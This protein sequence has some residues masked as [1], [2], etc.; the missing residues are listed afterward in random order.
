MMEMSNDR[1]IVTLRAAWLP[2]VAAALYVLVCCTLACKYAMRVTPLWG[3]ALAGYALA[4]AAAATLLP[5]LLRRWVGRDAALWVAL[6]ML[7]AMLL[8]VQ[9]CVDPLRVQVDRWSALAY[10]LRDLLQGRFPYL[11][12]THLDGYASPFPV[13]MVLHLPFYLL[14]DVGLSLVVSVV[15]FVCGVRMVVGTRAA[16]VATALLALSANVWYEAAVRSDL[17]TNF[18]LLSAFINV[19]QARGITLCR[20]PWLLSAAAGLWLSTRLTAAVP[21]YVALLPCW[22]RL[23]TG[24]RALTP[25]VAAGVAALTF[26]PLALWDAH[27]LFGGAYSPLVLQTRQGHV[28]DA[29][30]MVVVATLLSLWSTRG[31]TARTPLACGMALMA[32][33]VITFGHNMAAD[34]SWGELFASRYDI[35][36]L[37]SALPFLVTALAVGTRK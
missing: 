20:H 17:I 33:T 16:L 25:L 13:W 34:A 12:Q 6:A 24:R 7:A 15:C 27:A 21:L 18:L 14:G 31:G 28:A 11:A 32:V 5:R 9:H 4:T 26:L 2:L 37:D 8:A 10:P 29:A 19:S 23:S 1:T 3:Y 35:T 36:Y 22:L 30:V